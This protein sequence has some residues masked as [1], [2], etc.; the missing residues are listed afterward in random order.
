MKNLAILSSELLLL[1]LASLN[2]PRQSICS[3]IRLALAIIDPKMISREHLGPTE[4]S[5]A[6]ALRIHESMEVIVV[7]KDENLM[8]ATFQV[9]TP[10]LECLNDGYKLAVVGFEPCLCRNH[11][12]RK[13]GYWMPLAQIGFSDY[14]IRTS[15]GS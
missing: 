5:K 15:S 13:E 14:P 12:L 10:S 9:V 6:Q 8:L 2:K 4:L 1:I 11:F 3:R 7:R